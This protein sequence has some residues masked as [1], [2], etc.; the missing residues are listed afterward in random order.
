M[1][2]VITGTSRGIGHYLAHYYTQRGDTV[3]GCSREEPAPVAPFI[4]PFYYHHMC[5]DVTDEDR[6]REFASYLKRIDVLINNAG[7][8]SM[9][10]SL[11]TPISTARKIMDTN[12]I[13]TFTFSQYISKHMQDRGRIV[14]LSSVAYP[15][16]L[17]GESIYSAS[18]AAVVTLTQ[19]MAKE[20]AHRN[21]TVNAIGPTPIKTDLIRGVPEKKMDEVIQR[22]AIK[23]YGTFEDISN[24][25]DF[26]I[27]PE[28]NFI[29]GQV[30]YLG[31]V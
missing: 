24:V 7:I 23:R 29:T 17:E 3:W 27:K 21:I 12:F 25:I 30:I 9:N 1:D 6:V 2:I 11:L 16:L 14:N 19:I 4:D 13:A 22:Q 20:L 8:S 5:L 31:G 18:K 15:M 26:L 10:H 28:S